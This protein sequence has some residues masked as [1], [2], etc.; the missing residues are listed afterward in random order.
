M[1]H[2]V[3][4]AAPLGVLGAGL[5]VAVLL[6]ATR[7]RP[8]KVEPE[9]LPTRVRV[10]VI[11]I[12]D[13]PVRVSALGTVIAAREV[14]IRPEVSGRVTWKSD[15]LVPGGRVKEGETLFRIDPRDY[16]AAL[17]EA[18]SALA[19]AQFNLE[20]ERGRQN[21][22][23]KEF[24]VLRSDRELTEDEYALALRKPHLKKF[25]AALLGAE[26]RV[27]RAELDVQRTRVTAPFN[28]F[29]QSEAV[30]V[31]QLVTSQGGAES[32]TRLVGT[33]EFWIQVSVPVSAL[34]WIHPDVRAEPSDV[35][36]RHAPAAGTVVEK[37]GRV[38][39]VFG[40]LD[41]KGRMARL[42]VA[43]EDPLDLRR[44][45]PE[46]QR[47]LLGAY[48]ELTISG[49]TAERVAVIPRLALREGDSVWVMTTD[50]TL[51]I[52]TV[53]ASWRGLNDV[54]VRS[55]LADGDRLI[56]SRI[57]APVPGMALRTGAASDTREPKTARAD[58]PEAGHE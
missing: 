24:E 14:D 46:R 3:R 34:D 30:E 10:E 39:E 13:R 35:T 25:Q 19:E 12:E 48:V 11:E 6:V 47:L 1:N 29:V 50:D 9:V 40:D 43:V 58:A 21:I 53:E 8:Q 49:R 55:G 4:I 27:Q 32:L 22:A 36:V 45:E 38:L 5:A 41:P 20:Q 2:V 16:Q 54:Y 51:E 33:D 28:A 17:Q 23:R 7:P 18:R 52:R 57:A 37:P 26:S 56:V 42:L 31:G 44:P 15:G